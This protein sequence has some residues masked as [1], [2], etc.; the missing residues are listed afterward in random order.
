MKCHIEKLL[1]DLKPSEFKKANQYYQEQLESDLKANLIEAQTIW[2]KLL[3]L[4]LHMS[5]FTTDQIKTALGNW[6][7]VYR[8]NT[9]LKTRSEQLAYLDEKMKMILGDDFDLEYYIDSLKH[10]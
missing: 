9:R 5:G 6:R 2:I 3:V 1:S 7:S 4:D 8:Q 10:I